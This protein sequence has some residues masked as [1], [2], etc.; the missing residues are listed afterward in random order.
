MGTYKEPK[1]L[2]K[3]IF[4]SSLNLIQEIKTV[5]LFK[6]CNIIFELTCTC[7]KF[8]PFRPDDEI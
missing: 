8:S 5:I 7:C 1:A 3:V 2:R 4:I 6:I